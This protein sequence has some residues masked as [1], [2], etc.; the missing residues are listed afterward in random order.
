MFHG[1]CWVHL[2][3][4]VLRY[5]FSL[6]APIALRQLLPSIL[7]WQLA[8]ALRVGWRGF[9]GEGELQTVMGLSADAFHQVIKQVGNYS[10]IYNTNL[11]PVGLVR[12]GSANA[13]WL[14]GGLIYAP[15]AR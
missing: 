10:E 6:L 12:E 3:G 15:P 1:Q 11:N 14:D 13:G 9:G 8:D 4:A 5:P 7:V 2:V